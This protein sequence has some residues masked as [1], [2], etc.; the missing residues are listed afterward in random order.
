MEK[1]LTIFE[2]SDYI[3]RTPGSIRN[4]VLR[5][6]IPYRKPA[7]RLLF[8]REEIDRWVQMADGIS[9]EKM[10]DEN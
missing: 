10:I 2:L 5:R 9:L 3:K 7:G 1:Y 4:L 6:K 8:D